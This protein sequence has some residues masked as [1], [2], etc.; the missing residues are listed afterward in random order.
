VRIQTLL[1]HCYPL[2]S[3]VYISCEFDKNRVELRATIEPRKNGKV[4]CSGC[5][6]PCK[7]YDHLSKRKFSF[8]PLWNIPVCFEYQM[9]RV[10][11]PEC[12]V[13]VEKLPKLRALRGHARFGVKPKNRK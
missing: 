3:F 4:I 2:K 12:G 10:D 6:K 5:G 11:C 9:R 8:V 7:V 1:N 13:K